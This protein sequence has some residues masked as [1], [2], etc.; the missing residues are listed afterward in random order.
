MRKNKALY[1]LIHSMTGAEKR[2]FKIQAHRHST[3]KKNNYERLFDLFESLEKF[4]EDK[5]EALAKRA[6]FVNYFAAE[7]NYLYNLIL[8]SLDVFHKE[9]SVDRQISKLI[10]IG[11]ILMEKKLDIQ[12]R[13]V[14]EKAQNLS[15]EHNRHENL[16]P[17]NHLLIRKS[18]DK[19]TLTA[20]YL[21]ERHEEEQKAIARLHRK[22]FY[23]QAFD[24][25][26]LT[27][28]VHGDISHQEYIAY[29]TRDFPHV[30]EPIPA[31]FTM[32]DSDVYYLL[33]RLEFYR[34]SRNRQEGRKIALLLM[35]LME[36]N[37]AKI[38]GEYIDRYSYCLYVFIIIH[39]YDNAEERDAAMHK[40]RHLDQYIDVPVTKREHARTFEFH[41][42]TLSDI[43]LKSK[44]YSK[45]MDILPEFERAEAIYKDHITP[46]FN[47]AM[48]FNIAALFFGMGEYRQSLKWGNKVANAALLFRKD[49][50]HFLR[51][52]NLIIHLELEN[53][54]TLQSAIASVRY[55]NR[56][57]NIHSILQNTLIVYIQKIQKVHSE[58]EK[59][60]LF[61]ELREEF[62]KI[63]EM[64]L[65]NS[66]FE[67][68]D[69]LT[70]VERKCH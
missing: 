4:D 47:V 31:H 15:I 18:F 6:S 2:F 67:D 51:T 32:W 26:L 22:L 34:L 56:K 12:G 69:L 54:E 16:L 29:L 60:K 55:F 43:Y 5:I 40:L 59:K 66:V 1:E 30:I 25:L 33:S 24:K 49:I 57:E 7:K 14:L 58:K 46:S 28:R 20:Q 53:F 64:P 38:T 70:W 9:S 63:K 11:R 8:D 27:R 65:E 13:K 19:E 61:L 37:R 3:G 41:Y 23:R 52:L 68:L 17:I 45:I 10:N 50:Y 21:E 36:S 35:D 62:L 39:A 48:H 44:E 42:T